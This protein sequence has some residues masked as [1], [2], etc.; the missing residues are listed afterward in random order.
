MPVAYESNRCPVCRRPHPAAVVA[1]REDV[2]REVDALWTFHLRRVRPATPPSRLL[3]RLIFTLPPALQIVRCGECAV[4]YRDPVERRVEHVFAGESL[5]A[6]SLHALFTLH[7]RAFRVQAGR[8]TRA[9]EGTG[10]GLE[11]GSYTGAFLAAARDRGWRFE[12]VDVNADAVRFAR[13][14]GLDVARRTLDA[15]PATRRYDAIAIWNCFEQLPD[16]TT[17]LRTARDRLAPGGTIALRVPNGG[18]YAALRRHLRGPTGPV[19]RAVLAHSNLLGFPYRNGFTTDSLERLLN[20]VGFTVVRTAGGTVLPVPDA[21]LRR[22]ATLEARAIRRV[23]RRTPAPSA[24][25]WFEIYA[26]RGP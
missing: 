19:A 8:L 26:R 24:A 3:D 6:A 25:P 22:W 23:L 5:D 18:F 10:R 21:S 7:R 15:V 16:P 4:L 14:R 1:D 9:A 11:V 20:D 2:Q 12:G 13:S 17:V